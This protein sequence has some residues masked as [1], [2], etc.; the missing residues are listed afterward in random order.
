MGQIALELEPKTFRGWSQSPKFEF[1]LPSPALNPVAY[2]G[3]LAPG[4]KVSLG[5]RT[6]LVRGSIDPKSELGVKGRRKLTR[7]LHIF[8]SRFV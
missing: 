4:D 3:F 7:V 2:L 8:V 1:R 5:T 6:E